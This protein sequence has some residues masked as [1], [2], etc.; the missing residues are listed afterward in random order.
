MSLRGTLTKPRGI[1]Q[2]PGGQWAA[3]PHGT[4][5]SCHIL[6]AVPGPWLSSVTECQAVP[7]PP[8]LGL[9][10]DGGAQTSSS[11]WA[12][13]QVS[14]QWL[15]GSVTAMPRPGRQPSSPCTEHPM[16]INSVPELTGLFSSGQEMGSVLQWEGRCTSR[17][18]SLRRILIPNQHGSCHPQD[19]I[20]SGWFLPDHLQHRCTKQTAAAQA[21][22]G[23]N[24]HRCQGQPPMPGTACPWQG[25]SPTAPEP[26]SSP[27][28]TLTPAQEPS[29]ATV[30]QVHPSPA[31]PMLP[32]PRTHTPHARSSLKCTKLQT[33]NE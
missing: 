31:L 21:K 18:Y 33:P 30:R 27:R 32:L 4:R 12:R 5:L 19:H 11:P 22:Q 20:S 23:K 14:L 6:A 7:T 25:W 2:T 17:L 3:V 28:L 8:S 9:Q 24:H 1:K 16:G 26:S 15:Q 29:H 10:P 13:F